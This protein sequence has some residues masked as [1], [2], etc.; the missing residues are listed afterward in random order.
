MRETTS[1]GKT[2][3]VPTVHLN[4]TGAE[5][6]A[7]DNR[8]A[9]A[10]IRAAIDAVGRATPNARDYYVQESGADLEAMR[11]H[12]S[13][14]GRLESV[15]DEIDAIRMAVWRQDAERKGMR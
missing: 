8:E 15:L 12:V 2:I 13:R 14:L 5:S 6:L 11:E 7:K 10:A 4:G 9:S 1:K 3:R